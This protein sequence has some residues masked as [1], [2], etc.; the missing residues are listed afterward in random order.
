MESLEQT[1]ALA[2]LENLVQMELLVLQVLTV[3]QVLQANLVQTELLVQM[4]LQVQT[5]QAE[6]QV[7]PV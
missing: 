4:V 1:V 6:L 7:L 3:H 2:L 5:V